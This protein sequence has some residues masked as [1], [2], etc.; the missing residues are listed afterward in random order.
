M[1]TLPNIDYSQICKALENTEKML[2]SYKNNLAELGIEIDRLQQEIDVLT[3]IARLVERGD[4]RSELLRG[5]NAYVDI[6]SKC[7][8]IDDEGESY[9]RF[10]SFLTSRKK[11]YCQLRNET[12]KVIDILSKDIYDL[13]KI[14]NIRFRGELAYWSVLGDGW[15]LSGL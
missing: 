14:D 2:S 7:R 12:E 10:L 1:L 13:N 15:S 11:D 3:A 9:I 4:A 6:Y 5:K 8:L